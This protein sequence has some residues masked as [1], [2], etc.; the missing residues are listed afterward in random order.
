MTVHVDSNH[1]VRPIG[2]SKEFHSYLGHIQ[3][4]KNNSPLEISFNNLDNI[5]TVLAWNDLE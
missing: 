5:G 4:V 3:F 2:V 1:K